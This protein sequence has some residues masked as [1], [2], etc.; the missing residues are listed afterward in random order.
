M[1]INVLVEHIVSID[2]GLDYAA[3]VNRPVAWN[4]LAKGQLDSLRTKYFIGAQRFIWFMSLI[5]QFTDS[6]I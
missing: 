1:A 6:Y 3:K 2:C 5:L 4:R